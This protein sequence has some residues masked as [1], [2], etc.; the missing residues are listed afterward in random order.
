[1]RKKLLA[2]GMAA[3]M[4]AGSLLGCS[5]EDKSS[6]DNNT[7]TEG[8]ENTEAEGSVTGTKFDIQ[9]ETVE[10]NEITVAVKTDGELSGENADKVV[11]STAENTVYLK[12]NAVDSEVQ[13]VNVKDGIIT[14]TKSGT[15]IVTGTL[16]DGQIVVNTEDKEDV[17]IILNNVNIS[18]SINSALYVVN[19]KKTIVSAAA[20]TENLLSDA[21]EY[22]YA[23]EEDEEPSAC[24]F[25]KDDLVISGSGKLT[26]QGNF[27][28]GIA[29]KDTLEITNV[30]L[31]VTAKNNGIKGK[32]YLVVKSGT[33]TVNA[34]GDGLKSDNTKDTMLG[35]ILIEGGNLDITSGEDGIQA[36]TCLKITGGDINIVTGSGA[37]V[38]SKNNMWG[39]G[40]TSEETSKKAIKAGVDITV[41]GGSIKVDSEDDAV[42]SNNSLEITGGNFQL[43]SGDDGIHSDTSLVI[44]GGTIDITK[45]YE[46]IESADI[47]IN[48]GNITI[49]ASDDGINAAGGNDNSSQAARPGMN[50]FSSSTG[51]IEITGGYIYINAAGDGIDSN[52]SV[53]VNGGTILVDGPENGGN[54]ALDYDA[55]FTMTGGLLI[56]AGSSDMLQTVSNSSTQYCISTVLSSYQQADTLFNISDSKGNSVLTYKPSKK[57]NSVVVCIPDIEKDE[58]Y[59]VSCGGSVTGMDDGHGL[60]AEEIYS[61]GTEAGSVTVSSIISTIGNGAGGMQ[62]GMNNGGRP[63]GMNNGGFRNDMNNDEMPDGMDGEAPEMPDGIG[64]EAHEMPDGIGGEIPSGENGEFQQGRPGGMKP[65]DT[66]NE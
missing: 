48:G 3:V 44:N 2:I 15:Y 21:K 12:G 13:G 30:N 40:N 52:G 14:I 42:H 60:Y 35:Y 64:G 9:S 62:G 43:A 6:T 32:D 49:A 45:S 66:Q 65:G 22:T 46:G 47:V 17:W 24:I 63:G 58:T 41:T 57:Y 20:G 39:G 7:K 59:T 27:N 33:I 18:N 29:G 31:N 38:T 19:A 16:D 25:S 28:N 51:N 8:K 5:K 23:V 61:G 56:A 11:E 37:K 26:V 36:E 54:G 55:E 34:E 50:N 10:E 4:A 53:S 1:M